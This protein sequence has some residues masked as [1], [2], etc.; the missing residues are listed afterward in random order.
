VLYCIKGK[1]EEIEGVP[2][3][4]SPTSKNNEP[5]FP[6]LEILWRYPDMITTYVIDTHICKYIFRG[7]DLMLAGMD[8]NKSE[9]ET[10]VQGQPICVKV[11]GNPYPIGIGYC[12]KG[13]EEIKADGFKDRGVGVYH[14]YT[15]KLWE[16]GGSQIP[17][18]SFGENQVF[19]IDGTESSGVDGGKKEKTK[20]EMLWPSLLKIQA[21]GPNSR[22]MSGVYK[23]RA[24]ARVAERP[25][26]AHTQK[27]AVIWYCAEDSSWYISD[28]DS[29]GTEECWAKCES[30]ADNPDKI[31]KKRKMV[32]VGRRG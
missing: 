30:E 24:K 16:E 31:G 20:K 3:F 17:H 22:K 7:A 12:M 8:Q 28:N 21:K 14:Y 2:L 1:D 11:D 23:R 9:W 4:F 27:D 18:E 5:I 10:S 25:V 13:A 26:Y 29:F 19:P 6:T 15:D 32:H